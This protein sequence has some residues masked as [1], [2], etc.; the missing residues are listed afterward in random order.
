MVLGACLFFV[1]EVPPQQVPDP[2]GEREWKGDLVGKG[3]DNVSG[4]EET[5]VLR[6]VV[7]CHP[8]NHTFVG[9]P[10]RVHVHCVGI[11]GL[12]VSIHFQTSK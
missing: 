3:G 12:E 9:V 2:L 5:E 8:T 7:L 4:A 1:L 11:Q 6:T 10:H